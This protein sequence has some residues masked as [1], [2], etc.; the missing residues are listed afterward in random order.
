[1]LTY[2]MALIDNFVWRSTSKKR[3]LDLA[4]NFIKLYYMILVFILKD[5]IENF[6]IN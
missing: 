2:N 4:K 3:K 5:Q 1:M 6:Q